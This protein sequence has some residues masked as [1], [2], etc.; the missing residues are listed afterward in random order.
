[1]S[2]LGNRLVARLPP[3]TFL[4]TFVASDVTGWRGAPKRFRAPRLQGLAITTEGGTP[5]ACWTTRMPGPGAAQAE[6]TI[7]KPSTSQTIFTEAS[8]QW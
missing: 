8:S 7:T 6:R 1:M 5:S 4:A 2:R 3:V